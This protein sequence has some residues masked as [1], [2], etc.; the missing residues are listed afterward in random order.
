MT[1]KSS[2]LAHAIVTAALLVSLSAASA[3][4]GEVTGTGETTPIA[5]FQANSICSFSGLNDDP[6]GLDPE[7]GP[8]GRVQSFGQCTW[9]AALADP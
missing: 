8:R 7:N 6:E 2:R 3:L 1:S 4:A 9:Q 5:D